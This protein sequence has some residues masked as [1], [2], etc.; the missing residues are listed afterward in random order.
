MKTD[1]QSPS[2][3]GRPRSVA[4]ESHAGASTRDVLRALLTS[5]AIRYRLA[6]AEG[7]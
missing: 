4:A 1:P 7:Q 6:A 3:I 5:D 2:R